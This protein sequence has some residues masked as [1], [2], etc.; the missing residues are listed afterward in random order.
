M[1][2]DPEHDSTDAAL[3]TGAVIALRPIRPEDEELMVRFHEGLSDQSVYQR[4]FHMMTLAHRTAHARLSRVCRADVER[5][6]VLVAA[7]RADDPG[8]PEILGVARVQRSDDGRTAEFALVV[9]DRHQ[10]AG[11]GSALLRRLITVARRAGCARLR[12]DLLA[13]N[14]PM[15]R[16]C[17]RLGMS[18]HPTADPLVVEADLAL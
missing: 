7:A 11:V 17:A 13:D 18:I 12:A 6:F 1:A 10:R 2:A 15:R 3:L 4:Y 9:A 8:G 5:E 14:G 16:L